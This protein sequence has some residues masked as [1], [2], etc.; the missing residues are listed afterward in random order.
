MKAELFFVSFKSAFKVFEPKFK[1]SNNLV[2]QRFGN[3]SVNVI[4]NQ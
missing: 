1:V 2:N 3:D 4:E